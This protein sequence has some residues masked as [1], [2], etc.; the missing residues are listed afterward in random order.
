MARSHRPRRSCLYVPGSN[1]RALE[2]AKTSDCDVVIFDLEDAVAPDSK[3]A[4]RVSVADAVRSGA[5]GARELVVRINGLNT[6]WGEAD[7]A[8]IAP[9]T[10]DGVLAPKVDTAK[11]ILELHRTLSDA[12]AS[13]GIALWAMIETPL[14]ILNIREIA[15]ASTASTLSAFVMGTNDLAKEYRAE[16]RPGRE[17]FQM[18][19]G[20]SVAAARAYDLAIIDGVYNNIKDEAGFGAECD[21]GRMLGFDGKSVIHPSQIARCNAVFSPDKSAIDRAHSVI[22]AFDDPAN[23]GKGVILV[24]GQ[25]TELLHLE[26]ARMLIAVHDAIARRQASSDD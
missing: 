24:D 8:D 10:P 20:L 1:A 2:K 26:Q 5:Y 25:M 22:S 3:E 21:Q 17:A 14:A 7:I 18:A 6:D 11:D 15:E 19:F 12:D 4:A 16:M 23:A 13:A 9:T